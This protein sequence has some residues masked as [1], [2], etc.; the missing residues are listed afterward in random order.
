MKYLPARLRG[1]T[2]IELLVVIAIIGILAGLLLPAVAGAITKANLLQT[3]SNTRQ[4]HQMT[5]SAALDATTTGDTNIIGWP[6]NTNS[7]FGTTIT[8]SQWLSSMTNANVTGNTMAKLISAPGM[9]VTWS[10]TGVTKSALYVYPVTETSSADTVFL[11]TA[12]WK[13]PAGTNANGPALVDNA[14][15]YGA[16]GFVVMHQ[17]GNGN[18]YSQANQATNATSTFGVGMTNAPLTP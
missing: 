5:M 12:N 16:K 6:G 3:V 14:V 1:F 15:P 18:S 13:M 7:S 4:L 8:I 10:G 11:T 2:L 17:G 9:A